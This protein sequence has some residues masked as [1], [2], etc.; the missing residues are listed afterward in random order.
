MESKGESDHLLEILKLFEFL[1]FL[2]I[3]ASENTPFAMTPFAIP[4]F[5]ES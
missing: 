1:E 5:Y 3:P 4:D 2:E